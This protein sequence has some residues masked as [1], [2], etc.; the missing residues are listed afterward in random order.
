[1]MHVT[2]LYASL[3]TPL[4]VILSVRVIAM[5]RDT[6]APLGDGGNPE[7]LRSMR[8]HANFAEYVPLALILLGLAES[9]HTS[10]WLLHCFGWALLIGRL[11]HAI[12]V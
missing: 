8:V 3:L 2:A 1:M 4:F 9:L 6:G 12:G 11:S 5:R 10:V 7:L